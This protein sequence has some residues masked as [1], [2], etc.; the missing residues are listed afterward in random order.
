[1]DRPEVHNAF[2]EAMIAELD[3][4]FAAAGSDADVRVAVLAGAGKSFSA[5]AD[6]AWMKRQSEASAEAN[7][8]DARRFAAMLQRI[9]SCTKPT[10]A[11]IQGIAMGGGVGLA[12]ACD[13]VV[14]TDDSRFAVTEARFGLAASVI[15]PYLIAAV[16]TR[17]AKRLA[18][19]TVQVDAVEAQSMGLVHEVVPTSE[20]DAAVDTLAAQLRASGPNALRE[21]KALYGRLA[22][23]DVSDATRELTAQT[24]A[25]IRHSDE[26][27]E[28]FR[29]FLE[30]RPPHWNA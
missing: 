3:A 29:A 14:A 5:G 26:A 27:R 19:S 7:L 25:R 17:Q 20:L 15:G 6:I 18:M 10:V 28:G 8:Q 1:M 16:G 12:C 30:K 13:F 23:A 21:I 2:D 24:I 11:R 9:S 4:A 22:Q